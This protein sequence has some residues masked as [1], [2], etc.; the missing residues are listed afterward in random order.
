M[1]YVPS[2]V[3]HFPPFSLLSL[4]DQLN[5]PFDFYCFLI[6]FNLIYLMELVQGTDIKF[7]INQ[8][9]DCSDQSVS[10]I[11]GLQ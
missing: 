8:D 1:K 4:S 11:S 7:D 3:Y 6:H 2:V 9:D 5:N 10:D